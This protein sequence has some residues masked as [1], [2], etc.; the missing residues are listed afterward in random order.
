MKSIFITG[1]AAGIGLATARRFA[2][3]GWFVGLYD[4][5]REALQAAMAGGEFPSAC[6]GYCDVTSRESI[7][8][9]LAD[10]ASHTNGQLHILVNNAG[11][12]TAGPFAELSPSAHDLMI[13]IN[14][15][16]FTH[17][18]QAGFPYLKQTAGSCLVNLCSASSIHGIPNL[19]VYSASKFYVNGLTQALHIEWKR[20]GIRVTCVKPD[21][22]D[23]QM[24][25]DVKAA[26]AKDREIGLT[27]DDIAAAIDKAVHGS[28]VGYVVGA[29][30]RIWAAIDKFLPEFLRVKMTQRLGGSH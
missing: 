1:A 26:V 14:I 2:A 23:T 11:V 9:A 4:I 30:A 17:V 10:F 5:N 28:R 13:D 27:P 20:Q 24:A 16:G 21:L 12:L 29:P 6:S 25:H 22:V 18:A 7:D 8:A 3:Q 15:K 19:A